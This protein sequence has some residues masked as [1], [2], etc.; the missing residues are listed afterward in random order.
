MPRSLSHA[1]VL[2]D[3]LDATLRFLSDDRQASR[4]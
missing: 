3:D 2:T 1:V 4:R